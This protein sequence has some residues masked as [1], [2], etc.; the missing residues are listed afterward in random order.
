[1]TNPQAKTARQRSG[2]RAVDRSESRWVGI[3]STVRDGDAVG[4]ISVLATTSSALANLIT[5]TSALPVAT[6]T[7]KTFLICQRDAHCSVPIRVITD[8]A[9]VLDGVSGGP[10][11]NGCVDANGHRIA[12]RDYAIPGNCISAGIGRAVPALELAATS[13]KSVESKSVNSLPGLSCWSEL[14]SFESTIR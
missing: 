11:L 1:M 9:L 6:P 7:L 3:G 5:P 12:C 2:Y 10:R 13:V 8:R 4:H 14:L